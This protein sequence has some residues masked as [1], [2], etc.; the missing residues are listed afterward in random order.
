MPGT[1]DDLTFATTQQ[2]SPTRSSFKHG[3]RQSRPTMNSALPCSR[4]P[5]PVVG[6]WPRG[7]TS[8]RL[9]SL[10]RRAI[11]FLRKG[12]DPRSSPNGASGE[13]TEVPENGLEAQHFRCANRLN[14]EQSA[15]TSNFAYRGEP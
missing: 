12:S 15:E 4:A 8:T 11:G 1:Q 13:R 14:R 7:T 2:G 9:A 6:A 3:M 10:A 5:Q